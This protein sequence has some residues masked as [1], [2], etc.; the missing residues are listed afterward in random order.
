MFESQEAEWNERS[1]WFRLFGRCQGELILLR[2]SRSANKPDLDYHRRLLPYK[3]PIFQDSST[4][5]S[6]GKFN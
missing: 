2:V 6:F 5:T 3:R 1:G 4:A